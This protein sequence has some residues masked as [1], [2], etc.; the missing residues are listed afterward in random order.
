METRARVIIFDVAAFEADSALPRSS[1]L[2][3]HSVDHPLRTHSREHGGLMSWPKHFYKARQHGQSHEENNH[4]ANSMSTRAMQLSVYG[5][6][7]WSISFHLAYNCIVLETVD[8]ES[9]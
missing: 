4:Q 9:S 8:W 2:V 7:V 3:P 6:M 5:S 1:T